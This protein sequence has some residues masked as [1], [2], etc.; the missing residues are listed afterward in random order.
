[1]IAQCFAAER[2]SSSCQVPERFAQGSRNMKW[3]R[4]EH[5]AN[6]NIDLVCFNVVCATTLGS[7]KC[8]VH[9]SEVYRMLVMVGYSSCIP[10]DTTSGASNKCHNSKSKTAGRPMQDLG[11]SLTTPKVQSKFCTCSFCY[12]ASLHL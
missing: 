11:Q 4:S 12:N 8:V 9:V 2:M 10:V 5:F 1:M 7:I 3:P 6:I